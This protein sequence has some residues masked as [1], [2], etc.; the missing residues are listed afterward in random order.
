MTVSI[1]LAPAMTAVTVV[2]MFLVAPAVV[3]CPMIMDA[4]VVA[5]AVGVV[6]VQ[7]S[8]VGVSSHGN[9]IRCGVG[10]DKQRII[11]PHTMDRSEGYNACD[12]GLLNIVGTSISPLILSLSK[13]ER[14][15]SERAS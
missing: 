5:V 15:V 14:T 10:N 3:N 12:Q 9:R 7:F 4:L 13:D 6:G 2:P 8:R 1:V 11:V